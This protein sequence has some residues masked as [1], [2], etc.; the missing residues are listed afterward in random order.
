MFKNVLVGVDGRQGGRDAIALA[1]RLTEP[2]GAVTLAHVYSGFYKPSHAV[3]PGMVDEDRKAAAALLERE[4]SET[5]VDAELVSIQALTT[6][7]GLHERA[8]QQD[9]N[10]LVLGT[11]RRGAFGRTLLGNDT[12]AA[13]NG[14]PCAVAVAPGGFAEQAAPFA[15]IGVGYDGSP[16]SVAALEV[17]KALAAP[18]RAL[19]RALEIVAYPTYVFTGLVPPVGE[20]ITEM[21]KQADEH[22]KALPGVQGSAEYGLAGED[23]A[24]FSKEV[25]IL[26]VGSRGYGP[27]RRL[28]AGSTANYLQSHARSPLLILPRGT[29]HAHGTEDAEGVSPEAAAA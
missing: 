28:I 20:G 5:G 25:D 29:E 22:M 23:L 26:I 10:L 11:C 4:R 18:T 16:E 27:A 7:Q 24:A 14:A 9:A 1:S 2:G 21:V 3:A 19:V 6:G 13:I 12:R 8:E 15:S 17:A